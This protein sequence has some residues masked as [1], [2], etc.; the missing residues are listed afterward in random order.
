MSESAVQTALEHGATAAAAD[1]HTPTPAAEV[2]PFDRDDVHEFKADDAEA[3]GTIGKMLVGFFF[4]SL[5]A[6]AFVSWWAYSVTHGPSDTA[7]SHD[8][9][10]VSADEE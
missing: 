4:Y 8:D 1:P 3:A 9:H 6:M 2:A 7:A 5:I 10:A